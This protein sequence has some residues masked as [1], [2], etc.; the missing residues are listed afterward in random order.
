MGTP[1]LKYVWGPFPHPG[2]EDLSSHPSEP[3]PLAGDPEVAGDPGSLRMTLLFFVLEVRDLRSD[4]VLFVE[5]DLGV[6][7][8]ADA[9]GCSGVVDEFDVLGLEQILADDL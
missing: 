6:E 2:D 9:D 4:G 1:E 8:A 7:A 3:R 5:G